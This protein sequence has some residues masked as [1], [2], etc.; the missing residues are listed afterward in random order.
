MHGYLY[1]RIALLL[2]KKSLV[3]WLVI[4]LIAFQFAGLVWAGTGGAL[5]FFCIPKIEITCISLCLSLS[6]ITGVLSRLGGNY[7]EVVTVCDAGSCHGSACTDLPKALRMSDP[8]TQP[9][10]PLCQE[11]PAFR[12][13][14]H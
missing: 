6:D 9:S 3:Q 7:G 13:A 2:Q 5:S 8:F 4:Q 12:A 14:Q 1:N 10:N 11:R